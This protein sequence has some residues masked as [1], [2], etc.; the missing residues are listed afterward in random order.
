MEAIVEIICPPDLSSRPMQ[1][2]FERK[3]S[4]S[5]NQ[6]YH[7]WIS[8]LDLWFASP[9]SFIS[10]G[11]PNTPYFFETYANGSRIPHYGR[12][13]RMEPDKL[14]EF[15]WITEETNGTETVITINLIPSEIGTLLTLTHKGFSNE[16]QRLVH[17]KA[18]PYILE[19]LEIR[20]TRPVD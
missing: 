6:L 13:L 11:K 14:I 18:W 20:M 15:T 17:T 4:L 19:Q 3:M 10:Q 8:Q 16:A 5:A 2:S 7:A 12:F 1:T 9:G